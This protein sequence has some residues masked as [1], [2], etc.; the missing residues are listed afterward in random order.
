MRADH[1]NS[2]IPWWHQEATAEDP[3]LDYPPHR[4]ARYSTDDTSGRSGDESGADGNES[5]GYAAD[6]L[7]RLVA[8]LREWL[9]T[10]GGARART[11]W[12]A[13]TRAVGGSMR[14]EVVEHLQAAAVELAA[15]LQSALSSPHHDD[16]A[17]PT[18]GEAD[19]AMPAEGPGVGDDPPTSA[20]RVQRVDLD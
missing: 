13:A 4:A 7:V 2:S 1:D 10:G 14:P 17:H 3:V 6:E 19:T 20:R 18:G 16:A 11:T 12:D 5:T 15:A 8:A 9:A